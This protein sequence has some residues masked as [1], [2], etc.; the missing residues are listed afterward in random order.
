MIEIKGNFDD[1]LSTSL[2]QAGEVGGY[3][4]NSVNPFRIEGQK[5]IVFRAFEFLDWNAP[6]WIVYPGG[7]L[8]NTS[9]CG[10][11]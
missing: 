10:K 11:V 3:T 5:T 4:V 8:G 9:S 6:D 7:A 2:Q 1:A